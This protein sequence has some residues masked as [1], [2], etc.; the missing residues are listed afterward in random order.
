MLGPGNP[1]GFPAF[2]SFA[3]AGAVRN[4][5][6][7]ATWHQVLVNGSRLGVD[8]A[9]VAAFNQN[10]I[11]SNADPL[12]P[13]SAPVTNT[14]GYPLF[15][16]W[17]PIYSFNDANGDGILVPGELIVRDSNAYRGPSIPTREIALFPRVELFGRAVTLTAQVDHKGGFLKYNAAERN[18]CWDTGPCRAANDPSAPLALQA[19]MLGTHHGNPRLS[20]DGGG[21]LYDG[22]F[23][24][25]RELALAYRVPRS[26]AQRIRA[27][28]ALL[29]A[30][31]RNLAVLTRYP[32]VDPELSADGSD[33]SGNYAMPATPPLRSFTLRLNLAF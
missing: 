32:G 3:A 31:G 26:V 22:S 12:V 21:M 6:V 8:I 28:D 4:R 1:F 17:S 13:G 11:L 7:E 9:A 20:A 27:T 2:P 10:R 16:F 33:L 29:V 15:G 18:T 30:A 14:P 25:L 24:R 5:G 19:A 23:T